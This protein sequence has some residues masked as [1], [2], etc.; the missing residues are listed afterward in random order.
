MIITD[1]AEKGSRTLIN[2][3]SKGQI[4]SLTTANLLLKISSL[5]YKKNNI[6]RRS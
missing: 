3:T 2:I 5:N 4:F 1:S 6:R